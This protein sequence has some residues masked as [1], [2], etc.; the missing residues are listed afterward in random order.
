MST[1]EQA[2]A[3]ITV[4]LLDDHE[5]VRRGVKDLLEVTEISARRAAQPKPWREY[6]RCVLKSPF[7]TSTCRTGMELPSAEI[8]D[9]SCPRSAV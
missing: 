1:D 9:R 3:P 8:S 5:L 2:K 4:F 7:S 6:H